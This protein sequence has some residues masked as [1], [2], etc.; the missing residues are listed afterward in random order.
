MLAQELMTSEVASVQPNTTVDLA[1]QTMLDRHISGLPVVDETN[2]L[3]GIVTEGDLLRRS[4][5]GTQRQRPRW[6]QF[7]LSPGRRADEYAHA[8]GRRIEEVM[9]AD[10]V[11]A[12]EDTTLEALVELM[13][14]HRIKLVPIVR[15]EHLV[16]IVSRADV[17]RALSKVF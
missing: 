2:R 11:S 5:L 6:L 15:G 1:V 3:V 9:T 7:L 10:V 14:R 13:S 12:N 17:L 16:G 8:S 4:E